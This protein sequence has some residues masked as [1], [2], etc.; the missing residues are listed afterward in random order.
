MPGA[1]RPNKRA[2]KI[3]YKILK[4][5]KDQQ[6]RNQEEPSPRRKREWFVDSSQSQQGFEM[7]NTKMRAEYKQDEQQMLNA[8]NKKMHTLVKSKG[9]KMKKNSSC[10]SCKAKKV[11]VAKGV[12]VTRGAEEKMRQKPGSSNAGK[13][14]HVKP[15]NF[16]GASGGASKY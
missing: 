8:E 3:A 5:R 4:V 6:Q 11:T 14:K 7:L 15:K 12:K 10:S 13:Y 2:M 1:I 9:K 16:A